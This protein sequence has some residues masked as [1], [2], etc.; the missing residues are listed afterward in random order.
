[1]LHQLAWFGPARRVNWLSDHVALH[2]I[3]T[4]AE[5]ARFDSRYST[6]LVTAPSGVCHSTAKSI[7]FP[8]P[9]ERLYARDLSRAIGRLFTKARGRARTTA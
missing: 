4:G 2:A 9:A 1:M 5:L 8:H 7:I 6:S 3:A